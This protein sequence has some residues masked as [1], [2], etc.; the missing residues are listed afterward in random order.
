MKD[1]IFQ[2]EA[3]LPIKVL[4]F[5]HLNG[6]TGKNAGSLINAEEWIPEKIPSKENISVMTSHVEISSTYVSPV[7]VICLKSIQTIPL[8]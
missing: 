2:S 6:S 4:Y 8:L 7:I 1:H 5:N 3:I